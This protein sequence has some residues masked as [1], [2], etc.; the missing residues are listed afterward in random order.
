MT[1]IYYTYLILKHSASGATVVAFSSEADPPI[2]LQETPGDGREKPFF[3]PLPWPS[4][5]R[6]LGRGKKGF[7]L[8]YSGIFPGEIL[9][10]LLQKIATTCS[11]ED[12]NGNDLAHRI[13][14]VL[15]IYP[16]VIELNRLRVVVF[17][18]GKCHDLF[19]SS[20]LSSLF[21]M[22]F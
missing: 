11:P 3:F 19:L 13:G 16:L 7:F 10:D 2:S 17:P 15:V 4:G 22:Y 5:D 18:S 20:I 8:F 9:E 12:K 6:D 21:E 14:R 1:G